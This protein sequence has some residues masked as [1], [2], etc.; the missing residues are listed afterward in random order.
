MFIRQQFVMYLVHHITNYY[1]LQSL[2]SFI[3][4]S[5]CTTMTDDGERFR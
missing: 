4:H 3:V 2:P 1:R 5:Y